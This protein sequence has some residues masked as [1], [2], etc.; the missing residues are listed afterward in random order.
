M[1]TVSKTSNVLYVL[2]KNSHWRIVNIFNV[3]LQLR[4]THRWLGGLFQLT[5]HL[6]RPLRN[7]LIMLWKKLNNLSASLKQQRVFISD[8]SFLKFQ[9]QHQSCDLPSEGQSCYRR[10]QRMVNTVLLT[11]GSITPHSSLGVLPHQRLLKNTEWKT[12]NRYSYFC[13]A[14]YHHISKP[15]IASPHPLSNSRIQTCTKSPIS[16]LI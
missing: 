11:E 16:R 5:V 8:K 4:S 1:H 15:F 9:L 12:Q 7:K 13:N 2:K 6:H 3:L 10:A 14:L